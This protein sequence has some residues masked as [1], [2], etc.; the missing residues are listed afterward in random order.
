[1][2]DRIVKLQQKAIEVTKQSP[3]DTRQVQSVLNGVSQSWEN[4][5]SKSANR[6][7]QLDNAQLMHSFMAD[8]RE[9]VISQ[10]LFSA[11]CCSFL[12]ASFS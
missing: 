2:D 10:S 5:K 12:S 9:M 4:L 11:M 3:Q 6:K 1:M 8:S 7:L